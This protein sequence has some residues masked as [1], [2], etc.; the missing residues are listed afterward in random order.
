LTHK[1][2]TNHNPVDEL[3]SGGSET[4]D[5]EGKESDDSKRSGV[6]LDRKEALAIA[7]FAAISEEVTYI[8]RYDW[9][10]MKIWK[11]R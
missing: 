3:S 9:A 7:T 10:Q 5:I 1:H 4:I 6:V 11:Q 2:C 8:H